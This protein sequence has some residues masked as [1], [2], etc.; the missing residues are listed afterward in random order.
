MRLVAEEKRK[1]RKWRRTS[2]KVSDGPGNSAEDGEHGG[3]CLKPLGWKRRWIMK[4]SL[5]D[6]R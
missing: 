3:G 2:G 5:G 6:I 4:S 1:E